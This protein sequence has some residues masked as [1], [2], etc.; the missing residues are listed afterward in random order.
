MWG[1][2]GAKTTIV[3]LYPKPLHHKIIEPF[4]GTARYSLEHFENDILLVDKYDVIIK[5]WHFL[6]QASEKDVLGIN[7]QLIP[8]K[9]ASDYI[10]D[11]EGE[12]LLFQFLIKKA[13]ERPSLK[14]TDRVAIARPNYMNYSLKRISKQLYKIRHWKIQL[15]T[16]E[17]IENQTATWFFD[18][19]YEFGGACY[20]CSSRHLN[21][22]AIGDHCK[23]RL[24]QVIVCENMKATWLPF[25]P[26]KSMKGS[27][28]FSN[29]AIWTNY[30][31][32]FNNVQQKL[33]FS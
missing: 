21:F 32:H 31:T 22:P 23:T 17:E 8:Q 5:I 7:R 12:K 16:Y 33:L 24:G 14:V 13:P 1:Y 25:V 2:Y 6:Q 9:K 4:A 3:K 18:T 19:P 20:P 15:G 29:E 30:H 26:L 27:L 28:G 10:F 11:S